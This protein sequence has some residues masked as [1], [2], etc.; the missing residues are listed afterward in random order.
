MEVASPIVL[1]LLGCGAL[2]VRVGIGWY[3]RGA[4]RAKNAAG[5]VLRNVLD[6]AVATLAFWAIGAAIMQYGGR[7][8]IGIEPRL[9]FGARDNQGTTTFMN[10]V[11]VLIGTA[12]LAGALAER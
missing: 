3:G 6:L 7:S 8:P 12:P 11:F 1:L 4:M 10:L 2:L 5:V 9:L